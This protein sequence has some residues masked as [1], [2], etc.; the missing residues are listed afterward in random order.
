LRFVFRGIDETVRVLDALARVP[1]WYAG[2]PVHKQ[3]LLALAFALF[4]GELA[5]RRFAPKS[6]VYRKW[7]ALFM[8]IGHF[9][10]AVILSVVYFGTVSVISVFQ[11]AFGKDPLDRAMV[12]EPSFWRAHEPNPLGPLAAS[13]HQF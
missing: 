2:L 9:W 13:R 10:T 8:A 4:F 11:R 5:F 7:T 3:V 12:P 6:A 1:H